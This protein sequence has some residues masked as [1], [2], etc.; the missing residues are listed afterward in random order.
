MR[1]SLT[2]ITWSGQLLL[3]LELASDIGMRQVQELLSQ[4]R[5]LQ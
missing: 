3:V 5:R 4:E 1:P 2:V